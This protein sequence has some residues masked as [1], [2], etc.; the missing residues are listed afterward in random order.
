MDMSGYYIRMAK[1]MNKI[2]DRLKKGGVIKF[3]T[4]KKYLK[5]EGLPD[6]AKWVIRL[7]LLHRYKIGTKVDYEKERMYIER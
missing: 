2:K 4:L 5:N 3:S 6:Y 1:A 7:E